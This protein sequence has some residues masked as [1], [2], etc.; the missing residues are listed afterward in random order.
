MFSAKAV[1][2]TRFQ[3]SRLTPAVAATGGTTSPVVLIGINDPLKLVTG[4]LVGGTSTSGATD[5]RE[6]RLQFQE[7]FA[8]VGG[9][10]SM[11]F[12]VD[13]QRIK[14]T[15]I[16]LSDATGT[17]D[18]DSAGD[19]LANVPSRFRQNFLTTSTQHNTYAGIF[20]QDEWRMRSNFMLSYGLRWENESIVRD[21]DNFGPRLAF[22]YDPFKSGKT[23]IRGGAGIFYNRA[24][25]RTIDDFTLGAQR[26]FFDTDTLVDPPTG[27]V[28]TNAQR[29][30][31]IAANL[32]FPQTLSLDSPLVKQFGVLMSGSS[33]RSAVISFSKRITRGIGAC[34]FGANSTSTRHGCRKDSR[35][36]L[37]IWP[38]ATLQISSAVP[39]ACG[40]C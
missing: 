5:R 7:I 28:M 18:F 37:S 13:I 30:A 39:A 32:R 3:Y 34:I 17:W 15:F 26:L 23:V 21:G 2:Q 6:T 14:S 4:T 16:D 10:H 36:S 31:F 20:A 11:K 1:A 25:L 40:H 24:L 8:Y 38:R 22:A 33:D 12:G 29:R 27:K 9:N 35:T 19:F